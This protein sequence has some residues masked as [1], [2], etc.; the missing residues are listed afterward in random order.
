M[1]TAYEN[2]FFSAIFL[3]TDTDS[4]AALALETCASIPPHFST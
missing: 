1:L 4:I 3:V 2:T